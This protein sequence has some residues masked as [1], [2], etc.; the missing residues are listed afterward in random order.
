MTILWQA[1]LARCG[2]MHDLK[3]D[4]TYAEENHDVI[5]GDE[6]ICET[7][8]EEFVDGWNRGTYIVST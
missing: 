1:I 5:G 4:E 7:C 3:I 8:E 6:S 2:Y